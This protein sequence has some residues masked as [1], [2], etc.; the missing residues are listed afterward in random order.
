M[1]K[2]IAGSSQ[3]LVTPP[4]SIRSRVHEYGGGAYHVAA[5]TVYFTEFSSQQIH[6]I[7]DGTSRSR[8]LTHESNKR[9]ADYVAHPHAAL[10][11]SVCEDHGTSS[12][13]PE[14]SLVVIGL[15][16]GSVTGLSSGADFYAA[17]RFSLDGKRLAWLCWRHPFMPWDASELWL[18]DFDARRGTIANA[19]RVAGGTNEAILQ[20][21]WSRAGVLYFLSDRSNWWNVYR[22]QGEKPVALAPMAAEIGGPP[23]TLAESHYVL[24]GN[25]RLLCTAKRGGIS[26]LLSI[27]TDTGGYEEITTPYQTISGL[28][29][30]GIRAVFLGGS[31][32]APIA[33]VE[34]RPDD[35]HFELVR[36]SSDLVLDPAILSIP[37]A[38][39]YPTS[40]GAQAHAFYYP[41]SSTDHVGPTDARP[42]LIVM[43]HGGPTSATDSTLKLAVQYWTSRGF[44]VLDVNYGGSTGYGRL[45]RDRLLGQWG[46]RD[47]EDCVA[48]AL[49]LV[50][51]GLVDRDQLAIRGGSA[52][53]YTTLCALTYH[54]VFKAGASLYGVSDLETL[55]RDTHKFESRYLDRLVGPY[56]EA[57]DV[58][59]ARSPVHAVDRLNCPIIFFQ[60][61]ADKVVPPA[62]T[63]S[64]VNALRTKR[65]PVAYLS[66][67]NEQHGFRHA[68]TIKRVLDAELSF[69]AR[70]FGFALAEDLPELTIENLT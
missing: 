50:D 60:G 2:T 16:D 43:G 10:L 69:Y 23:W 46:I 57:A 30:D 53:G 12:P 48:G 3:E 18:A 49:D 63:E 27:N 67:P 21:Q 28:H 65:L 41:P 24:L 45:Y 33:L 70:I 59:R 22:L 56:P 42:P 58:Y 39:E 52:G 17:P 35:G 7:A 51:S 29:T 11:V 68:E 14:N 61:L 26:H 6:T 62:Q 1:R 37:S 20:P 36:S 8:P 34:Y 55:V 31:A 66:F 9:F 54:R 5:G 4:Q 64:M 19:R 13:E 38:I 47:V 15:H 32:T 44:A 25:N 40:D